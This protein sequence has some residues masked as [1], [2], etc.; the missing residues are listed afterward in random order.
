MEGKLWDLKNSLPNKY[1]N[2]VME[3]AKKCVLDEAVKKGAEKLEEVK[4]N[5][6][7]ALRDVVKD[8]KNEYKAQCKK[9]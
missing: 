3:K 4:Q 6:E 1:K 9:D 8:V 2:E 5:P 7:Q